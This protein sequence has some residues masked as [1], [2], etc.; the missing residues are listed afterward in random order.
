[1]TSNS[2]Q[3]QNGEEGDYSFLPCI[4]P[5]QRS[6]EIS[7]SIEETLVQED[8]MASN[9]IRNM[10]TGKFSSTTPAD[11]LSR[12]EE[13]DKSSNV[14]SLWFGEESGSFL[15][16]RSANMS[17]K[18]NRRV[19]FVME[20]C[21]Q[22]DLEPSHRHL[23]PG[24]IEATTRKDSRNRRGGSAIS[25]PDDDDS[26]SAYDQHK[27]DFSDSNSDDPSTIDEAEAT[28]REIRANL[29]FLGVSTFILKLFNCVMDF[30]FSNKSTETELT[31]HVVEDVS[32]SVQGGIAGNGSAAQVQ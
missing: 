26:S 27:V 20:D 25:E 19:K 30:L 24:Q 28:E 29:Y 14:S 22:P 15:A 23:T 2:R 17:T 1:M 16:N 7:T 10:R 3:K 21:S 4:M 6:Q 8:E 11:L 12:V 32:H 18:S 13:G 5:V 31:E 9:I